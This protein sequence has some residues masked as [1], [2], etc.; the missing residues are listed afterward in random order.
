MRPA[1]LSITTAMAS[2]IEWATRTNST[3]NGPISTG[4]LA[5]DRL[6]QLRSRA[7][8]AVLVKL[9][10]DQAEREPGCPDLLD[11]E[12]AQYVG[13][14]ADVIL[15]PVREDDRPDRLPSRMQVAEVG[16]DQIDA[17]V[18]VAREGD[19]GSMM[20][21]SPL[22]SKTVMFFPTSPSPPSGM[23]RHALLEAITP[24]LSA[25]PLVDAYRQSFRL[26][27]PKTLPMPL[28]RKPSRNFLVEATRFRPGA[29]ERAAPDGIAL[30]T[31]PAINIALRRGNSLSPGR[32]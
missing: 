5:G 16:Q 14:P 11:L 8:Q 29:A 13:K 19:P 25:R 26:L 2:G 32:R 15:V 12:L 18:L 17:E 3:R 7:Q 6:L 4:A 9:R 24:S 10:L 27:R 21:A 23:M 31:G 22:C 30:C 1:A 28:Y 20:I